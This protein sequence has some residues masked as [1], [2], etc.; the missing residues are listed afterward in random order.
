[1]PQEVDNKARSSSDSYIEQYPY[2]F[3]G[4]HWFHD[5]TGNAANPCSAQHVDESSYHEQYEYF[6]VYIWNIGEI[7][8]VNII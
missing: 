5:V 7:V 2:K 6:L 8:V 1:M 4:P 3:V